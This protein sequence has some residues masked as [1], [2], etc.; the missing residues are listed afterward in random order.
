V[1][2]ISVSKELDNREIYPNFARTAPTNNVGAQSIIQYL[3]HVGITHLGVLYAKDPYDIDYFAD[4]FPEAEVDGGVTVEG[5][6]FDNDV[7]T[8]I[9]RLKELNL[10]YCLLIFS[11]VKGH[12]QVLEKLHQHGIMGNSHYVWFIADAV[13]SMT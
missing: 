7:E 10:R 13:Q 2:A 5:V 12:K 8:T 6:A 3:K 4:V 9:T 11:K 1:S